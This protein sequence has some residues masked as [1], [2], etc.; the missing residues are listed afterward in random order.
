MNGPDIGRLLPANPGAG[1]PATGQ[2]P[3]K[4]HFVRIWREAAGTDDGHD[5]CVSSDHIYYSGS[6]GALGDDANTPPH[7][8]VFVGGELVSNGYV[9]EIEDRGLGMG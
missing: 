1:A 5:G 8:K 9:V 2:L 6:A 3:T 7:T 4:Q